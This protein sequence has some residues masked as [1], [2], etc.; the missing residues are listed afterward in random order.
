MGQ[1]L[2]GSDGSRCS[3]YIGLPFATVE[4]EFVL[5]MSYLP[6][7][8]YPLL[9]RAFCDDTQRRTQSLRV[10]FSSLSAKC[11]VRQLTNDSTA[12]RP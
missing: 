11:N 7:P 1:I 8:S 4:D 3:N 12:V 6:S 9:Q 10:K 2:G 5:Q